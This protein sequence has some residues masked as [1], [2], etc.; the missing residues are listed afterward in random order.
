MRRTRGV[1]KFVE[2][3]LTRGYGDV[4]RPRMFMPACGTQWI[5]EVGI[6]LHINSGIRLIKS[7]RFCDV[8]VRF[9]RQLK[10]SGDYTKYWLRR[11]VFRGVKYLL[12]PT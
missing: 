3:E 10:R 6:Y 7:L 8:L 12:R 5:V 1:I 2:R 11:Y 4:H 9:R